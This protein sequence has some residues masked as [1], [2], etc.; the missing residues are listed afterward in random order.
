MG[1]RKWNDYDIASDHTQIHSIRNGKLTLEKDDM[2]QLDSTR[3]DTLSDFIEYCAVNYTAERYMLFFWDHGAGPVYGFG[4][5]EWQSENDSLTLD[6]IVKALD[7]NKD[8]HFDII[9]MDSC[10]MANLETVCAM[11]PYC[12]YTVLSEDFESSLGWQYTEWMKE[13]EKNP[14]ATS[15]RLGRL[16]ID[17]TISTN[18]TSEDGKR[19]TMVMVNE[20]RTDELFEAW[21]NYAYSNEEDL[22]SA[23]YSRLY[24]ASGRS[25]GQGSIWKK[26]RNGVTIEDYYITD[27]GAVVHNVND[28]G[29]EAE[30]LTRT[31]RK[32]I[33]YLGRTRTNNGLNGLSVSLPYGDEEFYEKL[34]RVYSRCG[35]D[36]EYIEWLRKFVTADGSENYYDYEDDGWTFIIYGDEDNG[37]GSD[38]ASPAFGLDMEYIGD[39]DSGEAV[40]KPDISYE[41]IVGDWKYDE[42]EDVWY[43]K[44]GGLMYLYDEE[45]GTMYYYD[46][47]DNVIYYYDEYTGNWQLTE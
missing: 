6:E 30:E 18:E 34:C 3:S 4:Y 41:Y 19:T 45:S 38:P 39:E 29:D 21:K 25:S 43:L 12:D 42:S 20:S 23:N 8:V 17:S 40:N 7:D 47:S 32:A 9:G 24:K 46:D 14:Q 10:V 16:I 35:F 5:D 1:T 22:L 28:K 36:N 15:G 44:D 26:N 31:L 27:I 2:A 11:S 33:F 13:L 37:P